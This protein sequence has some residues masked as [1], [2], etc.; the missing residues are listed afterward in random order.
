MLEKQRA[1][2]WLIDARAP[3]QAVSGPA[4]WFHG[5]RSSAALPLTPLRSTLARATAP[6]LNSHKARCACFVFGQSPSSQRLK[7]TP[8]GCW[9]DAALARRGPLRL[10]RSTNRPDRTPP[11]AEPATVRVSACSN[12]QGAHSAPGGAWRGRFMGRRRIS[13]GR[14][15]MPGDSPACDCFWLRLMSESEVAGRGS[16]I[17]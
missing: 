12:T 14:D 4:S 10:R 5:G 16:A 3:R 17:R 6:G 11:D 2:S 9:R 7:R 15:S 8:A 1:V 13:R